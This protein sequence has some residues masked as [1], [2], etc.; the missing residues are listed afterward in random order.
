MDPASIFVDF[1]F[2]SCISQDNYQCKS[3]LPLNL[4]LF[5]WNVVG[6][7]TLSR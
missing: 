4:F 6:Q 5:E 1:A 2:F 3:A 7:L